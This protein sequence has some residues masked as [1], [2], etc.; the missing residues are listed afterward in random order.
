MD[1]AI[2][3]LSADSTRGI[4][5]RFQLSSSASSAQSLQS[6]LFEQLLSLPAPLSPKPEPI[7]EPR[8]NDI[9][10]LGKSSHRSRTDDEPSSD[11]TSATRSSSK[12]EHS[13]KDDVQSTAEDRA[14]KGSTEGQVAPLNA[15]PVVVAATPK[16]SEEAAAASNTSDVLAADKGQ[17]T[18]NPSDTGIASNQPPTQAIEAVPD[19]ASEQLA[20]E[21]LAPEQLGPM[22]SDPKQLGPKQS[23]LKQLDPKQSAPQQSDSKQLDTKLAVADAT[24]AG[25]AEQPVDA[26]SA[27]PLERQ[28]PQ[29]SD[30]QIAAATTAS[31]VEEPV[32]AL[33]SQPSKGQGAKMGEQHEAPLQPLT[34]PEPV[35]ARSQLE[36]AAA[37]TGNR[38][39]GK[40]DAHATEDARE[41]RTEQPSEAATVSGDRKP[42]GERREKW[43]ERGGDSPSTTFGAKHD[44]AANAADNQ[45]S[46]AVGHGGLDRTAAA[47]ADNYAAMAQP[48]DSVDSLSQ[49]L[50][51]TF[52]PV[53]AALIPTETV[54]AS[55]VSSS[56]SASP[57]DSASSLGGDQGTTTTTSPEG[58]ESKSNATSAQRADAKAGANETQRPDALTQ[59]ERVR[60][61]QRVSRSFSRL[62]PMGG[63]INIRLHPPQLGSLNVQVR[64]EGRTMTAKLTTETSAARDAILESLPVLRGRLAEQGFQISSFHVEVADNNADAASGN[65]NPQGAFDHSTGGD[66][67]NQEG[68][69]VDYRRLAAQQRQ[70]TGRYG[71]STDDGTTPRELAW[72]M[73]AGVDLQA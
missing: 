7:P 31:T 55:V 56:S 23:D 57:M 1:G 64:L 66:G 69:D 10:P 32:D 53:G 51:T 14:E 4:P 59:A 60:L 70:Q 72:Q 17:T 65:G 21:Q 61:V 34:Q 40:S 12:D 26:P 33:S 19:T 50:E 58:V 52:I 48:L 6:R 35:V 46:A 24:T 15:A 41:T 63:Q 9:E 27:Q 68:R 67:R 16:K 28:S 5:A 8:L 71:P 38:V 47:T 2:P 13:E 36:A 73:L 45:A 43:F 54:V 49:P 62:G 39:Q 30:P 42:R 37:Q 29:Q 25:T 44:T 11:S 22:Q 3:S 20:P 18:Q